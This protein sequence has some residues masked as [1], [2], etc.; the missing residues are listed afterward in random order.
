MEHTAAEHKG[1]Q[2]TQEYVSRKI[3]LLNRNIMNYKRI[4]DQMT[5]LA[6][7]PSFLLLDDLYQYRGYLTK[8]T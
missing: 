8:Q 1:T 7:G 4:F 2:V 5:R 3:E 6:D